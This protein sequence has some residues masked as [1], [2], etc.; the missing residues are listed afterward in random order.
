MLSNNRFYKDWKYTWLDH[1]Q[2]LR[3][4]DFK[5]ELHIEI[6]IRIETNTDI[7]NQNWK[8]NWIHMTWASTNPKKL[9]LLKTW[10]AWF[11]VWNP[12]FWL[13]IWPHLGHFFALFGPFGAIFGVGARFKNFLGPTNVNN[14]LCFGSTALSFCFSFGQILGLFCTFLALRGY[15]WGWGQVQKLFW[16]LLT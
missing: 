11:I 4:Y 5:C 14:Q 15:F 8:K 1:Q 6:G 10:I 7:W 13:L 9:T 16:D 12:I 3:P 2:T